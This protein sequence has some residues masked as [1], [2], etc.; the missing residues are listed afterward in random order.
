MGKIGKISVINRE[1]SSS[2]MQTMQDGLKQK[3]MTR[4]P[5]TGVFKFPY[6]AQW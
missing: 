5:G 2:G 3:K 6:K 1:Y 4:T